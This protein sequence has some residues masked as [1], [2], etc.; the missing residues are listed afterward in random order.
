M[1]ANPADCAWQRAGHGTR[2]R[3]IEEDCEFL[4]STRNQTLK[5]VPLY[6][7][8]VRLIKAS[9]A[10][11]ANGK[12]LKTQLGYVIFM[13]DADGRTDNVHFGLIRLHRIAWSV[14]AAEEQ[15]LVLGFDYAFIIKELMEELLGRKVILEA[16]TDS[17]TLFNWQRTAPQ[18][19]A[20]CKSIFLR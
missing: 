16:Y 19:C 9:A 1:W 20:G 2:V 11:F 8:T 5:F 15:D 13:A 14:M 7:E 6:M 10:S 17:C 12:G 3:N 4:Q 18:L